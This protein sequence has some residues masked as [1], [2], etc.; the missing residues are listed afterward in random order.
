METTHDAYDNEGTMAFKSETSMHSAIT[1]SFFDKNSNVISKQI[2]DYKGVPQWRLLY[3]YDSRGNT[4]EASVY[5]Y[6]EVLLSKRLNKFDDT[7]K[8]IESSVLDGRGEVASKIVIQPEVN[9]GQFVTTYRATPAGFIKTMECI[10]NKARDTLE[11]VQFNNQSLIR[12]VSHQYD[13]TNRIETTEDKV[14][15]KVRHIT[16]YKYDERNNVNER[17]KLDGSLLILSR[18]SFTYDDKNNLAEIKT[19]GIMGSLV[20][21]I[22]YIYEYDKESNWTKRITYENKTPVTVTLRQIEY[23]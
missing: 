13:N 19:Y 22:S 9:D 7:N 4:L 2:F 6:S 12:K 11:F 10:L 18:E 3:K 17:V 5:Q 1:R 20:D 14:I 15:E 21:L 16:H 8:L 23:Y